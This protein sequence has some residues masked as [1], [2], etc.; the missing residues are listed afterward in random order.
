M[1]VRIFNWLRG[2]AAR[3]RRTLFEFWDGKRFRLADPWP[4][5]RQIYSDDEFVIGGGP[6][7]PAD[8]LAA[9]TALDEPE[10]SKAVACARR[11]F[12][13]EPLDD[14]GRGGLTETETFA[15]MIDFLEWCDELVKKNVGLP[16]LSPPTEPSASTGPGCPEPATNSPLPSTCSPAESIPADP[17]LS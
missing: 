5:Y 4:I 11:A 8:M 16:T 10:F 13:V 1:F 7:N 6:D 15:L 12:K 2:R 9:A 14:R 17:S 3:Q